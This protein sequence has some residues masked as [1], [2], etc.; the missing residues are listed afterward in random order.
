MRGKSVFEFKLKTAR[1]NLQWNETC[2]VCI[3]FLRSEPLNLLKIKCHH[4]EVSFV[5]M[6]LFPVCFISN[7][8]APLIGP[9]FW[10]HSPPTVTPS[11]L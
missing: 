2:H 11:N 10:K 8:S 5:M 1:V 9:A 7:E 3:C 4:G 6:H